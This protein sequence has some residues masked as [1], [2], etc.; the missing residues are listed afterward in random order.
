MRE[1]FLVLLCHLQRQNPFLLPDFLKSYPLPDA[2]IPYG[3]SY[4]LDR[5]YFYARSNPTDAEKRVKAREAGGGL[6]MAGPYS[7]L[8]ASQM[9]WWYQHLQFDVGGVIEMVA[10]K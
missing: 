8:S 5:D 10:K 2:T 3:T 9:A 1:H 6:G 7:Y 4:E